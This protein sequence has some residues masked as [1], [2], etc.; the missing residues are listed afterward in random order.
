MR[1]NYHIPSSS[2]KKKKRRR[3]GGWEGEGCL[4]TVDV[5][6]SIPIFCAQS[7][8]FL[9]PRKKKRALLLSPSLLSPLFQEAKPKKKGGKGFAETEGYSSLD[10]AWTTLMQRTKTGLEQHIHDGCGARIIVFFIRVYKSMKIISYAFKSGRRRKK[11]I[12]TTNHTRNKNN[13]SALFQQNV[14]KV[15]LCTPSRRYPD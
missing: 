10:H 3:G 4:D 8:E 15:L 1:N 7:S 6:F 14:T 11:S 12:A 9:T 13:L 5:E 2:S